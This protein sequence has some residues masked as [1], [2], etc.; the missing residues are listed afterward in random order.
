[1]QIKYNVTGDRRKAMVAVM[2]DTLQDTTRY[3][4]APSFMYQVGV[5]T[6]DKNGTVICPD[7]TD[8]TQIEMLIRELAYDGFVGERIE[9]PI[10]TVEL[11]TMA[12]PLQAN[13]A[14]A[15]NDIDRLAIELPKDG[16]TATAMENLRKLVASKA[17][18]L[19]K[20]LGT[21]SL[22]I[23]EH[24][25]R[26]EFGWFRPTDDQAEIAAYYQLV[27][28]LCKLAQS[29]QR[30]N[31]K[32]RVVENERYALRVFLLRLGFIGPEYKGSR[33]VLLRNLSG[34]AAFKGAAGTEDEA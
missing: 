12:P 3:L 6:V 22:P 11:N 7:N 21:E 9:E 31:A 32:E 2:R 26:I 13:V 30:V 33:T 28:G 8:E 19:K 25:D 20:A 1:M 29:Q 23:T 4:G 14:P 15:L 18:L 27:Q 16:M 5:Y 10:R 24:P 17:M 34:S